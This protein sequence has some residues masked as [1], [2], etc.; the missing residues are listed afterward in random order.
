MHEYYIPTRA[1]CSLPL[2]FA[3]LWAKLVRINQPHCSQIGVGGQLKLVPHGPYRQQAWHGEHNS[4]P[5]AWGT[6]H[7]LFGTLA[8]LWYL[9]ETQLGDLCLDQCPLQPALAICPA[10]SALS[11][12]RWGSVV[13]LRERMVWVKLKDTTTNLIIL[14]ICTF[15]GCKALSIFRY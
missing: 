4:F 7:T 1:G 13:E 12:S 3:F 5:S 10:L 6:H 14:V 2:C 9:P 15:Q 8:A 11:I